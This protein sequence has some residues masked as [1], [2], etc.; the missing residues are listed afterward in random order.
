MQAF[1][2]YTDK[3]YPQAVSSV[4]RWSDIAP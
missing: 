4:L 3:Y 2:R 1:R